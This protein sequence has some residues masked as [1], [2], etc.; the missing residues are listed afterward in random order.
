MGERK[1]RK[2]FLWNK[3]ECMVNSIQ[4]F[5]TVGEGLIY[6]FIQQI[7]IKNQGWRHYL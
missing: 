3:Y 7:I 5:F 6:S 2:Y 1:I 4:T